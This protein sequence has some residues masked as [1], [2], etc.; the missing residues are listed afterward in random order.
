MNK[1]TIPFTITHLENGYSQELGLLHLLK[2]SILIEFEQV[3]PAT[4]LSKSG[5]RQMEVSFDELETLEMNT[6]WFRAKIII[7]TKSLKT[8]EGMPGARQGRCEL[9]IKRSD[10]KKAERT[11]SSARLRLSEYRLKNLNGD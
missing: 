2:K 6:G 7:E 10:R 4:G 8:L 9:R 1:S 3:D 5:V 11:I